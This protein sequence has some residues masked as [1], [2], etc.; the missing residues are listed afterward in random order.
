M[1]RGWRLAASQGRPDRMRHIPARQ[2]E[3]SGDVGAADGHVRPQRAVCFHKQV[4]ARVSQLWSGSR[5]DHVVDAVVV[6]MKAAQHGAVRGIDNAID[7]EGRYVATPYRYPRQDA[8]KQGCL[9]RAAALKL[10][11]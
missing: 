10:V 1:V 5:M 4:G 8:W 11:L 2:I 7:L 9:N 6:G 3:R